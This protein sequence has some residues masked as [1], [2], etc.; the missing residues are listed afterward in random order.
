MG[1]YSCTISHQLSTVPL[2]N[3]RCESWGSRRRGGGGRS[4]SGDPPPTKI[5]NNTY[6]CMLC[7]VYV[8]SKLTAPKTHQTWSIDPKL[9][10]CR[11]SIYGVVPTSNQHKLYVYIYLYIHT[12]THIYTSMVHTLSRDQNRRVQ[13]R[14]KYKS[15]FPGGPYIKVYSW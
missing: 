8:Q 13:S 11:S 9:V 5:K 3:Y 1:L 10:Q 7:S 6:K 4:T 2:V 14:G 12:C 15:C